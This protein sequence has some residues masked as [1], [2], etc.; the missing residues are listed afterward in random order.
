MRLTDLD[1]RWWAA[2]G[3]AGQGVVFLCPHC[4]KTWL[5][6]AFANPLDGGE[7]WDVGTGERRPISKLWDVLYGGERDERGRYV[8][9]VLQAGEVVVPPGTLWTRAGDT[10]DALTLSP[11]VDAS[12]AGCWHGFVQGG[13]IA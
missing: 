10:F 8:G 13:G 4:R 12:P 6:V 11:S 7:P 9:G 3:R 1:P 2:P 5:C